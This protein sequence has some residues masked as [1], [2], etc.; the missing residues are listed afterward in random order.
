MRSI[1]QIVASDSKRVMRIYLGVI[2]LLFAIFTVRFMQIM[3][4]K[5]V[6]GQNLT[7]L[8]HQL[9]NKDEVIAS[10]RGNIYDASGEIIAT[11]VKMY[12]LYAVLTG[13]YAGTE[14]VTDKLLTARKLAK[15]L[16]MSEDEIL[17]LLS[18]E[19]LD[20]TSFGNAGAN[21]SYEKKEAI[22]A[23]GL[24][25]LGFTEK[26]AR[27]YPKGYFS[28]NIIGLAQDTR[29]DKTVQAQGNVLKGVMGLELAYNAQLTG[30]DGVVNYDKDSRGY[31]VPGTENVIEKVQNGNH[32]YTTLNSR[33]N[34]RLE[35]L[36]SKI[37]AEHAPQSMTAT[38]VRPKT[39][40]VVA[41]SQRPTFNTKTQDYSE[42]GWINYAV[43]SAFEPGSTM[44]VIALAAA[45]NE[46]IYSPM[47]LYKSGSVD[48]GTITIRDWNKQGW[49]SITYIEGLARSSNV[50]FVNLILQIGY[51]KWKT[52]LD[53][54]GFGKSTESGFS[55]E[56]EG[57][58]SYKGDEIKASTSFGQGISV[59]VLQMM[60][61]FSAIANEGKMQKL[62]FV[63]RVQNATTGEVTYMP[64][65]SLNSP[66]TKETA[67]QVLTYLQEVVY[68]R[69]GTAAGYK[70]DGVKLSVK[71]GTAQVFD[72][73]HHQ[74]FANDVYLFS[75]VSFVPSE[76]PEYIIYLTL[77]RPTQTGRST[78]TT[79]LSEMFTEFTKYAMTY[80]KDGD[81]SAVATTKMEKLPDAR[82]ADVNVA[83]DQL[84]QIG[85]ANVVVLGDGKLVE[86]QL[87]LDNQT[88]AVDTKVFLYAG[89]NVTMPDMT[90]WSKADVIKFARL[91]HIN[92]NYEG[93]GYVTNQSII[94]NTVV[95]EKELTV[96]LKAPRTESAST[97]QTTSSTTTSSMQTSTS[98]TSSR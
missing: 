58:N 54:F 33:L 60:Q 24:K 20:Q 64:V 31:S 62:R 47:D 79:A 75:S 86:N 71:T 22:E 91:L 72:N 80:I 97:I 37:Y 59:T 19:G 27:D 89:G 10:K 69:G 17:K 92:V 95:T 4:L 46:G 52:Y 12:S 61:A 8:V 39:G 26:I 34:E 18:Q 7:T 32:V 84:K 87:P 77:D 96:Q 44:K 1:K 81:E 55:N 36:M 2:V 6:N 66:I 11:D 21:L 78:G 29:E 85:F 40:D 90:G 25:G 93:E 76:N 63:D 38:I 98:A 73:E 16:E 13:R 82:Q 9:Y 23:E 50:A 30:I 74:Y 88:Y 94:K 35:Q 67:K 15:H 56:A 53:A 51:D 49:G 65:Q 57:L 41:I 5:T 45:V 83:K 48:I 70:I 28:N 3:L 42:K 14:Y 43:E 68:G